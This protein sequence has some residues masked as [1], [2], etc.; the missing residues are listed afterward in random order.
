MN[1]YFIKALFKDGTTY[2]SGAMY[3]TGTHRKFN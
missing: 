1:K 3:P 2:E